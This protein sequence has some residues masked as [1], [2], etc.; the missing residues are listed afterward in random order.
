LQAFIIL[1][2]FRILQ[3]Q[4]LRVWHGKTVRYI[5]AMYEVHAGDSE[6]FLNKSENIIN[7]RYKSKAEIVICD[8]INIDYHT[9]T[10]HNVKTHQ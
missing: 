6:L 2:P 3:G 10:Y 1:D 4:Y 7:Y 9:E 8:D 5:Q